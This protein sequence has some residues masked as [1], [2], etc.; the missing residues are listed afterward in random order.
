MHPMTRVGMSPVF[1]EGRDSVRRKYATHRR[2]EPLRTTVGNDVWIGYGVLVK[3]G[4]TIGDGAV[5]G[6]G[7]VVTRDVPPY[8]IVAGNPAKLIRPRFDDAT[9]ELL[10]EI[11]WWKWDDETLTQHAALFKDLK[12]FLGKVGASGSA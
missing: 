7:S 6:M 2:P 5:V 4:V 10:L 9:I 8:A 11:Q 12:A 1:Y 3:Q